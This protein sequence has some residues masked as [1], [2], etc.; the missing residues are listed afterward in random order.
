MT[1]LKIAL[2]IS[3][4]VRKMDFLGPG[5]ISAVMTDPLQ[6]SSHPTANKSEPTAAAKTGNAAVITLAGSCSEMYA[7]GWGCRMTREKRERG[8]L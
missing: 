1:F 2:P 4:P 3:F 6:K 5:A 8:K 7:T